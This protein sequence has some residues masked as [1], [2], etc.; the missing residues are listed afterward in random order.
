[1]SSALP[2]V[3][4]AS[5]DSTRAYVYRD[6]STGGG[7]RLD[8][9]NLNGSLQSGAVYPLLKSVSLADF[10]NTSTGTY[11]AIAMAETPDGNTVFVSGNSKIL[12][13]PV[14]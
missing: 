3:T 6:D 10:P 9:Y 2:G 1:M 12:V 4:L 8:I 13:V 7:P 11:N 5:R 14:N